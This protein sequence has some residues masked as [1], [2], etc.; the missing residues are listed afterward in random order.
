VLGT[1]TAAYCRR[2]VN[3]GVFRATHPVR[4]VSGR[5]RTALEAG[6][7]VGTGAGGWSTATSTDAIGSGCLQAGWVTGGTAGAAS[8]AGPSGRQPGHLRG[9]PLTSRFIRR[10]SPLTDRHS[11]WAGQQP[12]SRATGGVGPGAVYIARD[13]KDLPR[14]GSFPPTARAH[15]Q[16][17][18]NQNPPRRS[19]P[20]Q[21]GQPWPRREQ[22]RPW[23]QGS[24]QSRRPVSKPRDFPARGNQFWAPLG[25]SR[26]PPIQPQSRPPQWRCPDRP[27][28]RSRPPQAQSLLFRRQLLLPGRRP[29]SQHQRHRSPP[30]PP[31]TAPRRCWHQQATTAPLRAN[32]LAFSP[33]GPGA[34]RRRSHRRRPGDGPELKFRTLAPSWGGPPAEKAVTV[35]RISRG[36]TVQGWHKPADR[37]A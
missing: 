1:L 10:R 31:P 6:A 25:L 11:G 28:H 36:W 19:Q 7:A 21:T 24:G 22:P 33:G 30:A 37:L 14:Y 17:Q 29:A 15:G 8:S 18:A 20:P 23:Q 5:R 35:H 2:D 13:A 34:R 12:L 27:R 4:G 3:R 16:L 26:E 9:R 32:A